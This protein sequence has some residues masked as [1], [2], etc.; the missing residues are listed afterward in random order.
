MSLP[1]VVIITPGT[2]PIPSGS[3]S[4]VERVVEYMASLAAPR[5]NIRIFGKRFMGQEADDQFRGVPCTRVHAANSS[6]YINQVV[7]QLD[8][9]DPDI[10]QVENRPRYVLT[11]RKVRPTARIW[12]NLHS[13]TFMLRSQLPNRVLKR[14]LC[15]CERIFVNSRYL[16]NQVGKAAPEC[17]PRIVI[18]PLGVD[19]RRFVSRWSE[20]GQEQYLEWRRIHG[21]EERQLILF[22]GRLI[23]LKGV[24]HLLSAVPHVIQ[25]HP[26]ALF[27]IIGGASYG[28][29]H[30]TNYIRRLERIGR[31]YPNHVSFLSYVPHEDMPTWYGAADLVVVPSVERE[32]FGLVNV[33]AM[34]SGAPVIAT[35]VGGIQEVVQ[36]QITGVLMKPKGIHKQ[37]VKELRRMLGDAETRER[38]GKAGAALAAASFTWEGMADRW[39]DE[40]YRCSRDM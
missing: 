5:V 26:K 27:L 8:Q 29:N 40:I 2:F 33:E 35:R 31:R 23:P 39:V 13:T 38:M 9:L 17:K 21:W 28:K 36:H 25:T 6:I 15:E 7:Q 4:S 14:A 34:A 3:S 11:I 10:I 12:L 1:S 22:A 32:S 24:H 19:Q 20:A 37:L 16:Y 30:R 18:N